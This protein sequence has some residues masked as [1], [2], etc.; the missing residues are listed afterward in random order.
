MSRDCNAQWG[1]G[2]KITVILKR[3]RWGGRRLHWDEANK[4]KVTWRLKIMSVQ[5]TIQDL[6]NKGRVRGGGEENAEKFREETEVAHLEDS[7]KVRNT[8][9]FSRGTL[10]R[11]EE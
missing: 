9:R 1:G 11:P 2:E 6:G 5:D 10:N 7:T 8:I 4:H 3:V